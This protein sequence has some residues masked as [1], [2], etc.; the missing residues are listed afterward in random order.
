MNQRSGD[1]HPLS[2]ASGKLCRAVIDSRSQTDTFDQ[3]FGSAYL[4]FAM[5]AMGERGKED[6]LQ[7]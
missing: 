2:F 1:S 4:L 6:V 3:L 7:H 5:R